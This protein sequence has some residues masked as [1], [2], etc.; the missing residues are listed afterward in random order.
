MGQ[1]RLSYEIREEDL[2]L[3]LL[4]VLIQRLEISSRMVRK[5]KKQKNITVNG[6]KISINA[7]LR[8]GDMVEVVLDQE[9]NIFEPEDIP[10]SVVFENEDLMVVN[11]Q[12]FLVVHPTKGHP[13]GTLA[14]AIANHMINKGENYKIRFINRLDRDTSGL[15]LIA[16]NPYAQQ[17]ISNQMRANSVEKRY[18]AIVE[19]K[20]SF[21]E[22]TI[23]LPI[24]REN[25]GDIKRVVMAGGGNAVT[26]FTVLDARE[27]LS[28]VELLLE[29]GK[30][31]Q[32]RVHLSHFN[33][34]IIGDHLY[35]SE[36]H[37]ISR[38]ALHCYK[39]SFDL[40]RT[41]ER[42]CFE[43]ELPNDMLDVLKG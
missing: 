42:V 2:S 1:F 13:H 22:G 43:I 28:K 14:N 17:I 5:L 7:P 23:D 4:D 9:D 40:P 24:G 27:S 11:K 8:R 39:M 34:P 30:T 16:K 31:H 37:L 41:K 10:L 18:I 25:E 15:M 21:D 32:I 12:P 29:T 3:S 35:G 36:S 38:Q 26:H 20:F 6:Y 33:H 19:G